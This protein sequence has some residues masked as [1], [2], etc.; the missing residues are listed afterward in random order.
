MV[1]AMKWAKA[2]GGIT[3]E[4]IKQG[5]YAK[6][7]WVPEGLE[8]VCQPSTW[9]PE[10]H[11]GTTNVAINRGSAVDGKAQIEQIAVIELPRRDDWIG[12]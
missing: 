7:D 5:A 1:E 3:G 10:D 6:T 12:Y 2:N 11:R 4:N 8:G 9:T